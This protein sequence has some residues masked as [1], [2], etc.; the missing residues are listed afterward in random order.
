LPF[1][2]AIGAGSEPLTASAAARSVASVTAA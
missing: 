1:V 2:I